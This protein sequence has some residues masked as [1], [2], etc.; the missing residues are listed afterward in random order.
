MKTCL[1][2]DLF[3]NILVIGPV[4]QYPLN[5]KHSHP[6]YNTIIPSNGIYGQTCVRTSSPTCV[7]TYARISSRRYCC[8]FYPC[9][10]CCCGFSPCPCFCLYENLCVSFYVKSSC[11]KSWSHLLKRNVCLMICLQDRRIFARSY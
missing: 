5:H 11:G 9:R 8:D 4:S 1:Q 3:S 2:P 7:R 10:H 6:S